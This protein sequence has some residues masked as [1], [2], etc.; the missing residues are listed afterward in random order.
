M[1]KTMSPEQL[2]ANRRNAQKSTGPRTEK[3]KTRSSRN[4][5]RHGFFS[6][7]LVL[8]GCT[9]SEDPADLEKLHADFYA[10]LKPAS[11]IE[12]RLVDR[13]VQCLWLARRVRHFEEA[14][15]RCDPPDLGPGSIPAE[16]RYFHHPAFLAMIRFENRLDRGFRHAWSLL[17]AGR[18]CRVAGAKTPMKKNSNSNPSFIETLSP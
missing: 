1:H 3:G 7:D 13:M 11:Q 12:R 4:N 18:K 14:S 5:T 16:L 17:S 8:R 10:D 6:R 15:F 2:A 9:A